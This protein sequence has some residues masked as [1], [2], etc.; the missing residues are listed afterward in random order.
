[1]RIP[2]FRWLWIGVV[3]GT[4]GAWAQNVGA[5]WLFINDPNAATIVPLVQTATFLPMVLLAIPAGVISDAFDRRRL[6]IGV[7]VYVFVVS[8]ALALLTYL[9]LMPPALLLAFTFAIGVGTALQLPTWQPIIAELV[10]RSQLALATRLDMINV[11]VARA[12]GPALAGLIIAAWGVPLVFLF[13]AMSVVFLIV[14]L[15]LWRREPP[16]LSTVRERFL[17]A[18]FAGTR[19]VRHEPV[20]RRILL[21][22][23]ALVLPASALWGLLP[24][25]AAQQLGVSADGF[26][27]LFIGIGAGAVAG[28]FTVGH[29]KQ[30]LSSNAVVTLCALVFGAA[31]A[32]LALATNLWLAMPLMALTGYAWTTTA[33]VLMGELQLFLPGWVRARGLAI[34]LMVFTLCQAVGA[35]VWGVVTATF[36]L[37]TAIVASGILTAAGAA[38]GAFVGIQENE[39]LDRGLADYWTLS[40]NL[41]ADIRPDVGPVAVSVEYDVLPVDEAAFLAAMVGVRR[42]R[43]RNGAVRWDL[44]RVGE[45]QQHFVE[46]FVVPTWE[47]HVRQHDERLTPDDRRIEEIAFSHVLG[48]PT[49]RH[50][51]PPTGL[52]VTSTEV[53]HSGTD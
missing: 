38:L 43:L 8:A 19:Y 9:G 41:A 49:A 40:A 29:L 30:R 28:A 44:Y 15:L 20:V 27:V 3:I 37:Q 51:L 47:E 35:P 16:V 39:H 26:G 23:A 34:Y 6:L 14:A 46:L 24:L 21:R 45:D 22:L 32:L 1:L 31:F 11:N 13:N 18:L 10:P 17:P 50:L 48:T 5:Q 36:G 53:H 42:S 4:V 12:I 2:A 52:N 7:Q 25:I 33:A